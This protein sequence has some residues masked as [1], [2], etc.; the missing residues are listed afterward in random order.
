MARRD[1]GPLSPGPVS[2]HLIRTK[3]R[4]RMLDRSIDVVIVAAALGC[5]MLASCADPIRQAEER[6]QAVYDHGGTNR[7]VC[8]EARKVEAA[9]IDAGRN[10]DAAWLAV[11]I[12][13]TNVDG[14]SGDQVAKQQSDAVMAHR[15]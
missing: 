8:H 7:E 3:T 2:G 10:D 13:C 11:D 9:Y 14:P 1:D 12:H 5:A 4:P 6:R 15:R